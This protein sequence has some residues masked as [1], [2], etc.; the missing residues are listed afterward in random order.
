M[1][2]TKATAAKRDKMSSDAEKFLTFALEDEEF[3]IE[4]MSVREIIGCMDVTPLP[5]TPH[6]VKGITNLRGQ[7]I[8]VIDI[9]SKF[10]M[11]ETEVTDQT[12]IIVIESTIDS[13]P[14]SAGIIVDR[15]CEVLD[16]EQNQIDDTPQFGSGVDTDFIMGV[17][18]VNEAVKI[19][20]DIDKVIGNGDLTGMPGM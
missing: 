16:I 6:Y 8:P 3:G 9:R 5:Q 20:L 18:K 12:C 11:Q 17:G 19:L 15:V 10:G 1:A 7:V 13:R 2:E 4:I 14:F